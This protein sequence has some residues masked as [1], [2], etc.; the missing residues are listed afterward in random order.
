MRP[1]GQSHEVRTI[2]AEIP[3]S[4]PHFKEPVIYWELSSLA[5]GALDDFGRNCFW[6][7]LVRVELHG[8]GRTALGT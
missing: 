3:L 2:S 4:H 8:V 5:A 7:L 1:E 6:Y